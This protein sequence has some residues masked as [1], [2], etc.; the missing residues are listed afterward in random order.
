MKT[1]I[2]ENAAT[3]ADEAV[4]AV[5]LS[6][7]WSA[8]VAITEEMGVAL[9]NTAYSSAV[10]EGDDFSTGLFDSR[11]RLVAQ[12]NFTPG[13][14]GA[15]PFVLEHIERHFPREDRKSTRLNSSH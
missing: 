8:L 10:R 12:G 4:D 14:L 7:V 1:R 3:V 2:S 15:M 11:G 5:T 9:R 13:H 6:V